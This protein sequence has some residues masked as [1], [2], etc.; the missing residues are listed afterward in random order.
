MNRVYIS[1]WSKGREKYSKE[2]SIKIKLL[3]T[4]IT[5]AKKHNPTLEIC[6]IAD[7]ETIEF[8]PEFISKRVT[9]NSVLDKYNHYKNFKWPLV[10]LLTIANE[11]PDD[12]EVLHLDFDLVWAYD[13]SKVIELLKTLNIDCLFQNYEMLDLPHNY[14]IDFLKKYPYSQEI[15]AKPLNKVAY[16]AGILYFN[17]KA[18]S[19]LKEFL[20]KF[21]GEDY[22]KFGEYC[23]YEQMLLPNYLIGEECNLEVCSNLLAKLP[24]NKKSIEFKNDNT[25]FSDEL[26]DILCRKGVFLKSIGLYHFLGTIKDYSGFLEYLDQF[27]DL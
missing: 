15:M 20:N 22:E 11:I 14:Y 18:K 6:F 5:V 26:F 2:S 9:L 24:A 8:L 1:C 17:T 13:Y 27:K 25:F 16:V 4:F 7:K 3:D 21:N 23:A 12:E 10:K 19:K